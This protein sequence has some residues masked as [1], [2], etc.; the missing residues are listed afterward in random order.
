MKKGKYNFQRLYDVTSQITKNLNKIIDINYYPVPEAERSNL[1]H[2][3]IGIGVQGLADTFFKMR[4]PFD[5][6][7]AR[8]LNVEIFETIYFAAM[9]TSKDLAKKEGPYESFPGS[10]LSL[11]KFQFDLCGV[12]PTGRWDWESLRQ[13]VIKHG[14][15]NSLLLAP[16]PTASTSQILGNTECFEP[17]TSNLFTRRVLSGEFTVVNKYLIRDL[18]ERGL[19]NDEMKNKIILASGSVQG[20]NDIPQEIQELYK[21]AWEIKQKTIMDLAIDRGAFIDQSQSL[22][23]YLE[24]V[25]FAKLSSMHFY[26]WKKGLKTGMYYLRTRPA[27]QAIKFTADTQE[28]S[29][30]EEAS[31]AALCELENPEDCMAC[32][33]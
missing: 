26:A 11:G 22:N 28:D 18:L 20:M 8:A 13:E 15:R 17:V 23:I 9:T 21:T 7:E 27:V 25:N 16:M 10:P 2:R 5:S 33:S 12:R 32:G 14:A 30:Q 6:K 4:F 29:T 1:R 24:E 19:W 3:P 31:A